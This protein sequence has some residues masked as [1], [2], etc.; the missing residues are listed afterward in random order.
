VPALQVQ[1]PEFKFHTTK[2]KAE[3]KYGGS[4]VIFHLKTRERKE[5]SNKKETKIIRVRSK[6]S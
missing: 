4:K 2:K 3:R 6:I 5:K 1:S